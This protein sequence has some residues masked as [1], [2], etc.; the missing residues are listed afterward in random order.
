MLYMD[1]KRNN[2]KNNYFTEIST[3]YQ[4]IINMD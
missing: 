3:D 1:Y 2:N 4:T